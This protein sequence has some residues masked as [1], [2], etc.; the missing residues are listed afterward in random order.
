MKNY[1]ISTNITHC[2][3]GSPIKISNMKMTTILL[4][5]VMAWMFSPNGI[6]NIF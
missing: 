6:T 3:S 4:N 1:K 5:K 2:S